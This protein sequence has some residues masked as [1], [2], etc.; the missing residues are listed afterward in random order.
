MD[1][2]LVGNV[3][4]CRPDAKGV[5]QVDVDHKSPSTDA[6]HRGRDARSR[7][8]GSVMDLDRRCIIVQLESGSG[9]L[10]GGGAPDRSAGAKLSAHLDVGSRMNREVHVRFWEGLGV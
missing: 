9:Q 7:D 1:Q 4:T 3:R 5:A 10:F 6:G 8:E 2:A